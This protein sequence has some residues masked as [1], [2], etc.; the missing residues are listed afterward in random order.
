MGLVGGGLTFIT[1]QDL[2][3]DVVS[4]DIPYDFDTVVGV[5]RSGMIP[6]AMLATHRNVALVT[7]AELWLL[8]KRREVFVPIHSKVLMQQP[9]HVLVLDDSVHTGTTIT[10][11]RKVLLD[12]PVELRFA[13]VYV[14]PDHRDLVD[15]YRHLVPQPRLFAWNFMHHGLLTQACVDMD[16]V[17]CQ[18]PPRQI[19]G[20]ENYEAE[21][22]DLKPLFLPSV[23]VHTVITC[24]LEKDRTVTAAWL[25]KYGVQYRFLV[26][27][28]YDSPEARR[29]AHEHATWKVNYYAAHP[30]LTLFIESEK[31]Q[32]DYIRV[33][34]GKAVVCTEE[35]LASSHC[36]V[37]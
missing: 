37:A 21:L 8:I 9:K 2:Y 32:A 15:F 34:T 22:R 10:Y 27:M 11:I 20:A 36:G 33:Q 1:Y 7:P 25:T 4:W 6:A 3:K 14:T 5:P 28:D 17:L 24:R 19:T 23:P 35:I 31:W 13:A 16:G 18:D 12:L 30:E 26:M 29:A